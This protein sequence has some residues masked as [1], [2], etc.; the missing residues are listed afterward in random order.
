[1]TLGSMARYGGSRAEP[2]G[3]RA[4]V[5]GG[6]IVAEPAT[7]LSALYASQLYSWFHLMEFRMVM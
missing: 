5:V 4:V 6:I 2:I 3:D 7:P 1:M